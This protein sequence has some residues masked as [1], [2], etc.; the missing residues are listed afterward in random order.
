MLNLLEAPSVL[1]VDSDG[2]SQQR[3]RLYCTIVNL[4]DAPVLVPATV[5]VFWDESSESEL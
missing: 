3:E 2:Q 4:R 5:D 1:R